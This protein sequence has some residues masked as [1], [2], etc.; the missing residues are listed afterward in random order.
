MEKI[1]A[2]SLPSN[3]QLLALW[4]VTTSLKNQQI[5]LTNLI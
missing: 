1:S 3:E 5:D 2:L 4:G